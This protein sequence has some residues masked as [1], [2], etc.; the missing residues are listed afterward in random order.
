[1][2]HKV[3]KP[4]FRCVKNP[5]PLSSTYKARYNISAARITAQM[6]EMKN[7]KVYKYVKKKS[8][9]VGWRELILRKRGEL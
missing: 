4:F 2:F 7:H 6:K 9:N 8:N 3:R 5:V 1:M